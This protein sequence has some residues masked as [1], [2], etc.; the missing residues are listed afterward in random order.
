MEEDEK[1]LIVSPLSVARTTASVSSIGRACTRL[2]ADDDDDDE[3]G[4]EANA[5]S[6]PAEED[7]E[8][9][10]DDDEEEC[11]CAGSKDSAE[12]A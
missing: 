1:E 11:A 9:A 6:E 12:P 3:D 4:T 8:E 10:A 2:M 5:S 7:A